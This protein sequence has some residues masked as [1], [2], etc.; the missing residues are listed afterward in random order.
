MYGLWWCKPF[1]ARDVTL[2]PTYKTQHRKDFALPWDRIP[3]LSEHQAIGLIVDV[4]DFDRDDKFTSA[5]FPLAAT[6]F[7]V[8]H[9]AAFAAWSWNFLLLPANFFREYLVS[10]QQQQ[11]RWCSAWVPIIVYLMVTT[12]RNLHCL[13]H[14]YHVI[15]SLRRAIVSFD[16]SR[17]H[18]LSRWTCSFDSVFFFIHV[19]WGLRDGGFDKIFSLFL[20]NLYFIPLVSYTARNRW[21]CTLA[22][23]PDRGS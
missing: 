23:Q 20:L 18:N 11:G 3:D 12:T 19:S 13:F 5:V 22:Y 8:I 9:L 16:R 17:L 2:V 10:V 14:G 21:R 15:F 1:D 7:S 4:V 6:A